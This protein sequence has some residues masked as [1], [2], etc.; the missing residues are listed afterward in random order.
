MRYK[1]TMQHESSTTMNDTNITCPKC[2]A[3]FPL[4]E[5]VSHRLRDQLKADFEKERGQLNEALTARQ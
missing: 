4:S 3:E 5:A 2:G 1:S